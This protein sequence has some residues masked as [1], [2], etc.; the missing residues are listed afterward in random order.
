[1]HRRSQA[2]IVELTN[3]AKNPK[4]PIPYPPSIDT[5]AKRAL[6]DNLE[7]NEALAAAIDSDIRLK[8]KDG[9]RG[10]RIKER[11]VRNII[12]ARIQDRDLVEV[13]FDIVRN[14]LEY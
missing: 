3:R 14:Q 10:N 1:L 4:N 13:I 8:R 12:G 2:K 9:W 5:P 11:E 6:Y 7:K